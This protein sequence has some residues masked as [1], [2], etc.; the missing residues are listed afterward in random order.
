MAADGGR[1]SDHAVLRV[2]E[3]SSRGT[4]RYSAQGA[5]LGLKYTGARV[6]GESLELLQ[7]QLR[8]RGVSRSGGREGG[9]P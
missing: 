2:C 9:A 1:L 4:S 3:Q 6:G 7:A 8:E 5:Y